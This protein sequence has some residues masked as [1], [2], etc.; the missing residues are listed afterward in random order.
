VPATNTFREEEQWADKRK[1]PTEPTEPTDLRFAEAAA[2]AEERQ[3]REESMRG[4]G[5]EEEIPEAGEVAGQPLILLRALLEGPVDR[6]V[7]E[8]EAEMA[9]VG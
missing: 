7:L 3:Q 2:E 8:D 9:G 6:A 1:A 5:E 4:M